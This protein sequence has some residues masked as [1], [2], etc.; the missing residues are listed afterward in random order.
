MLMTFSAKLP[1]VLATLEPIVST[2]IANLAFPRGLT[3]NSD[4]TRRS[5]KRGSRRVTGI[6]LGS[7]GKPY[8]GRRLKRRIR[9]MIHRFD[10]LDSK[11]R[12]SLAGLIAY[13]SGFDPDFVNSLITKYGHSVIA[14]ARKSTLS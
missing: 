3:V 10:T 7:D 13:A 12:G 6:T 5:S 2:T 11:N 1:N 14:R 9:G 8:V 4:K